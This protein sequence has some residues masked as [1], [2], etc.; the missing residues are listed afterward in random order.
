MSTDDRLDRLEQRVGVLE[1]LIRQLL[2]S[3]TVAP[4]LG[5]R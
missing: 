1:R 3:E 2:A 4:P 5:S